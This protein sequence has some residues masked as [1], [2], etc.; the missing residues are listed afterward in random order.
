VVPDLSVAQHFYREFGLDIRA[1]GTVLTINTHGHPHEWGTIG[2]GPRKKHS[3]MSF[4]AFEDDIDQFSQR[5]QTMGIKRLDPPP[6]V[7]SNGIWFHDHDGNLVEIKVA[8]KS[9]PDEKS[10]FAIRVAGPGK[11]GAP[12]RSTMGRTHPRRLAHI[13][14]FT[15]DMSKAT[16]AIIT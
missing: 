14:M 1:K 8:A 12:F 6:G 16:E 2:E 5:L 11:R 15:R 4:G 13:L 9:S 10:K 7:D 3:H